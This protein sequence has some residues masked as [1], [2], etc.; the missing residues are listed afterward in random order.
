M[1]IKDIVFN[2]LYTI[3]TDTAV[4]RQTEES[5]SYAVFKINGNEKTFDFRNYFKK[6]EKV[7]SGAGKGIRNHFLIFED[8]IKIEF[9]TYAWIDCLGVVR[10]EIYIPD[11]CGA[12]FVRASYPGMFTTDKTKNGYAVIPNM[13]GMLVPDGYAEKIEVMDGGKYWSRGMYMPVFGFVK[14]YEGVYEKGFGYSAI[15]ETPWDGYVRYEH[16]AGGCISASPCWYDS[17]DRFSYKRIMRYDFF[18]YGDYNTICKNY[19]KYLKDKGS[20]ITLKEKIE[21]NKT[22]GYLVGTP[23]IHT[24]IWYNIQEDSRYYD[25]NNPPEN[26]IDATFKKRAEQLEALKLNGL[27]RAYI[28]LDGWGKGGYDN[29]HPDIL[30]PCEEAGGFEGMRELS[31]KCENI[32]YLFGLHDQYRDYYVRA[33]TFTEREARQIKEGGVDPYVDYWYGGKQTIL[34]AKQAPYYVKRNYDEIFRQGV[35]VKGAYLDVF[36][37]V[38]LEECYNDEHRMTRRECMDARRECFELIRSYGCVIQSEEPVDWAC[39]NLDFVHHA[40]Y[41]PIP[42]IDNGYSRGISVPLFNIVF[43]DSIVTPWVCAGKGT[44]G[45]PKSDSCELHCALNAGM[46]Y[47][48]INADK[49]EIER[50]MKYARLQERCAFSEFVEHKFLSEDTREQS[51][52]YSDGTIINVNFKNNTW[53]EK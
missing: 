3:E 48:S 15:C 9:S 17:L 5:F 50:V 19:R 28:H 24:S 32:G 23:L 14:N 36:A 27:D 2:G 42:S 31:E 20:F 13:Q 11:V 21:K 34:C 8:G 49:A 33:E 38:E 10:F 16:E 47:I 46:P 18:E 1:S 12:Q 43:H 7:I 26:K 22:A 53:T 29:L 44:W 45:I 4:W 40:P 37:I 35:R 52:V 30:P 51:A 25:K 41:G 39:E 6:S